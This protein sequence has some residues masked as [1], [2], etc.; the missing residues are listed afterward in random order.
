MIAT[1]TATVLGFSSNVMTSILTGILGALIG[2][3]ITAMSTYYTTRMQLSRARDLDGNRRLFDARKSA[4]ENAISIFSFTLNE[5]LNGRSYP[6]NSSDIEAQ[7]KTHNMMGAVVLWSGEKLV[8][9]IQE[10]ASYLA[11]P[12]PSTEEEKKK[13]AQEGS[14]IW[15][16]LIGLMRKE[17]GTGDFFRRKEDIANINDINIDWNKI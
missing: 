12:I 4:Y 15:F 6:K 7:W 11:K 1:T 3:S 8:K 13:D 17:I 5:R 10:F 14:D 2:G 16:D 9:K